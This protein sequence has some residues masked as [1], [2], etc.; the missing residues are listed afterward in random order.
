VDVACGLNHTV[1]LTA[2]GTVYCFGEGSAG[3]LG[4]GTALKV[5]AVPKLVPFP[6][7][8]KITMVSCGDSHSAAL[9]GAQAAI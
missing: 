5:L 6:E 4:V 3:Q 1:A 2:A 9:S 7:N 8:R